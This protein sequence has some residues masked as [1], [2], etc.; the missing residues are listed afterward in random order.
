MA[1][2]PIDLNIMQRSMDVAQ[3]KH[4]DNMKPLVDQ[5]NMVIQSDKDLQNRMEQV[6]E[7]N[8]SEKGDTRHDAR[9]KGKN[10]YFR[11]EEKKRKKKEEDEGDGRV[12]RKEQSSFDIKI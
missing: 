11:E 3:I 4:N 12:I 9:E 6:S 1:V 7:S 5:Q 10:F 2:S 8:K